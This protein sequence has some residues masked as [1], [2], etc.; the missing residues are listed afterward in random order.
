[1]STQMQTQQDQFRF[2]PAGRLS[3]S[4]LN[5]RKTGAT[6]GIEELAALIRSQRVV[7]NL[8]V[9]EEPHQG[10]KGAGRFAVVAG[11]RRSV[12]ITPSTSA[13]RRSASQR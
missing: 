7:Q 4:S 11:G 9:Y 1:M 13:I 2:I 10:R 5:V 3:L 12:I 6:E 8:T